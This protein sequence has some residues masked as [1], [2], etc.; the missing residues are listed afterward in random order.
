M[1]KGTQ[2][3]TYGITFDIRFGCLI[4]NQ[5]VPEAER[6]TKAYGE[7]GKYL[8][9]SLDL[10]ARNRAGFEI[11]NG[12]QSQIDVRGIWIDKVLA[13][14][15]A[16]MRITSPST[17]GAAPGG[18]FLDYPEYKERM[19]S[20]FNALL[21]DSMVKSVNVTLP[22]GRVAAA[23]LR[24]GFEGNHNV[25]KSF[26]SGINWFFGLNGSRTNLKSTMMR[27]LKRNMLTSGEDGD[28]EAE[29]ALDAYYYFDVDRVSTRS[30]LALKKYDKVIEF[31]DS[32]G[33]VKYRFGAYDYQ[34]KAIELAA[35]KEAMD[36]IVT[37]DPKLTVQAFQIITDEAVTMKEVVESGDYS[38]EE[39]EVIRE[40][41]DIDS[42][43]LVA[44]ATGTLTQKVLISSFLALSK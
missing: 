28:V 8:N 12:D 30:D 37:K 29:D 38:E 34:V 10:I 3:E 9:N 17:I 24:Y 39:L 13:T 25:N 14:E 27:S 2:L 11:E 36:S 33:V 7:F 21:T 43:T 26:H 31:K 16:G 6:A 40:L 44:V 42:N 20:S 22:N 41:L 19:L 35:M 15:M 32:K 18:N 5:F 4:L 1:A 23:T